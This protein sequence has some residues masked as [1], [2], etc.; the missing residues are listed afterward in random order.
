MNDENTLRRIAA[1]SAIIAAVLIL[2]ATVVLSMAVD[3]KFEFLENPADLISAG[4]AA[5]A[6]EL[7]RW[8]SILEVFGYFLFLI[9]VVLYLWYWIGPRSSRMVT[10]YTILGLISIVLGVI[11]AVMRATFWP[12]MIIAYSQAAE[13]QR[14]VLQVV[15]RSVTDFTFGGLYAFDTLLAGLWWLGIGLIL[16]AERRA[17]G[18]ATV[19]M[20]IAICGAGFGWLLQ[21]DPLARLEMFYFFEPVWLIW[22]GIVIYR[23][24][25]PKKP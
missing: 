5:N 11:G 20:G 6:A 25:E 1:S 7:F 21:I 19:I 24:D 4:L 10:L 9:P 3:F 12:Q 2:A 18:I 15:F 14:Q 22:I 8:G 13:V 16:R 23:L 17:L